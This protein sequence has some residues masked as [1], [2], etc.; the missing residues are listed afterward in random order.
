MSI[1]AQ[2]RS[3]RDVVADTLR[4]QIVEGQLEPGRRLVERDLAEEYEV[5]RI[6]LREAFQQLAA[7]GMVE[8]V[9]RKGALVTELT[10]TAVDELFDVRVA[11][12][13]LAA[14][15]AA[16]R[17]TDADL[18]R[19]RDILDRSAQAQQAGNQAAVATLNTE[20]HLAIIETA[21]NKMLFDVSEPVRGHLR[22]LFWMARQV[23]VSTLGTEHEQLYSAIAQGLA[24][25]A[26][27]I[28]HAHIEATRAPTLAILRSKQTDS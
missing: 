14:R 7:E 8:L 13:S 11:L 22:R 27:T 25:L 28:A 21:R 12:E 26:G 9:P 24:E 3:L 6:T 1:G 2:F 19:L 5:S 16:E 4:E 10:P 17:R 20:F 18:K 15:R 23:D